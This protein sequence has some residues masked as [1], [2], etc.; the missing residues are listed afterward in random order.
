MNDSISTTIQESR[1]EQSLIEKFSRKASAII[2]EDN[3]S[4]DQA[5][6]LST[7]RDFWPVN[8]IWM[9]EGSMPA[10]PQ[11]VVWPCS[12]EDAAALLKLANELKVAV[13]PYGE[14][15]G[16]MGGVVPIYGGVMIDLKKMN[17]I[18]SI[19]KESL[20]VNVECGMNGALYEENLNREGYTGGHFP[21]SLRCSSVGGWL[22][23]RAAGQF[24][25]RYGK[26]E[27]IAVTLEAVLP[28]GTIF[29][30][31]S[32]P[33]TATGPRVDQLF[34][35]S[36]GIFGIIT[37]ATLRIWP[38]PEKRHMVTYT[39]ENLEES[40]QAICQVMHSGA[41]PAVVRLYDAQ[42]TGHHFPEL[43]DK[44]CGL[45]LLIEGN[46]KIVDAEAAVIEKIA[47]AH[48]A[49][50]EGPTHVEHWLKKRFDVSVASTLFQKGAVLDTI[51]VSANWH[52]AHSTYIAMQQALMAVE[53]TMLASGHYSH[54]YPDGAALYLTTVGF[55]GDDKIGFYKR[56]WQAAMEACLAEGAAISHHH[57]I[58]L[59]RGLWMKD[60]H[61]AG[62][63]VLRS[64]KKALDPNNIMNPGKLG[65]AEVSTWQK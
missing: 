49:I 36:E 57:G 45:I 2:G 48:G 27:D 65:L 37:A 32:V 46:S 24:S 54:V 10:L 61:G 64:I 7:C 59:H 22:A 6:L 39:F 42:E 60:E 21:Q 13:I 5:D 43:G 17:R 63:E 15:S 51:E 8:S 29:S 16:T 30:G 18:R 33:R 55:P 11:L 25:T 41:R 35:G 28:D 26:I 34:L 1:V 20:M 19:D 3:V 50:E 12:T 47:M 44:R 58:G 56:I 4:S 9:L 52:N 14:G 38:L 62:L 53:G 23:C 31:R 40:L